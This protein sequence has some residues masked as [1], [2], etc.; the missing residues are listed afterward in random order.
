MYIYIF[1][2]PANVLGTH[3]VAPNPSVE[4]GTVAFPLRFMTELPP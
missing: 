4:D 3:A 2:P 1:A